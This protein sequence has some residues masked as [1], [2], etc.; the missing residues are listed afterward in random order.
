M[1]INSNFDFYRTMLKNRISIF[2]KL[3]RI[4]KDNF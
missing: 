1:T 4:Q 3:K 2:K